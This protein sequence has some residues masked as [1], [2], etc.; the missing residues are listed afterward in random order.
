MDHFKSDDT[1]ICFTDGS[2]INNGQKNA[3]GGYGGYFPYHQELNFSRKI[4][5][6]TIAT[7]NIA[8]LLAILEAIKSVDLDQIK[9]V[10]IYTDSKYCF[11]IFTD[12]IF[13]WIR[14]NKINKYK[15]C[16]LIQEIYSYINN[17]KYKDKIQF[18]HCLSH[19]K[20]PLN[21]VSLEYFIWKGNFEADK[22]AGVT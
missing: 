5:S 10:L 13:T 3:V 4:S 12:W 22:L 8:E 15:N 18:F 21:K 9:K 14:N 11:K 7:N 1:I 17:P 6:E 19:Q 2:C 20:E 16:E